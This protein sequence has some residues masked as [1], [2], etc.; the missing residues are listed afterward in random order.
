MFAFPRPRPKTPEVGAPAWPF[1]LGDSWLIARAGVAAGRVRVVGR[2]L[3]AVTLVG[4]LAAA[5]STAGIL[6]PAGSWPAL[7]LA[8]AAC[9]AVLLGLAFSPTLLL[10][11]AIDAALACLAVS[12]WWSPA[13]A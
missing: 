5:L 13:N 12:G 1:D 11:F 4:F 6:V 9:S 3:M 10:G 2:V 8:S 7:V